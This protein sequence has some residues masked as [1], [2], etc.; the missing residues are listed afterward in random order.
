MLVRREN[1]WAKGF[2]CLIFI[3]LFTSS[4]L[5]AGMEARGAMDSA[6]QVS[7]VVHDFGAVKR[8]GG[9]VYTSFIV[10]NQGETPIN[11]RR[12]WTS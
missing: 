1:S 4:L 6:L 9:R 5:L 12:I 11:I 7:P 8:L 2:G 10:H 3:G